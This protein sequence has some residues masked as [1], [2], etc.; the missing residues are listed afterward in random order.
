MGRAFQIS[1]ELYT[2]S[3]PIGVLSCVYVFKKAVES[4]CVQGVSMLFCQTSCRSCYRPSL[5]LT[6]LKR[7]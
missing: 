2:D 3:A 4:M 1:V 5:L 7:Q 6:L